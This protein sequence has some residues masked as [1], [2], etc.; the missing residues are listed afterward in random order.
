MQMVRPVNGYTSRV[1]RFQGAPQGEA[2]SPPAGACRQVVPRL[3]GRMGRVVIVD[4]IKT[5]TGDDADVGM[6]S[7]PGR[8]ARRFSRRSTPP[9]SVRCERSGKQ[10]VDRAV[11]RV[12]EPVLPFYIQGPTEMG[13]QALAIWR[14]CSIS[15]RSLATPDSSPGSIGP[16]DS[17]LT[18]SIGTLGDHPGLVVDPFHR[19]TGLAGIK[20]VESSSSNGRMSRKTNRDPDPVGRTHGEVPSTSPRP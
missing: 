1:V 3:C 7:T 9:P 18:Q 8:S 19:G 2:T 17:S 4:Q 5:H 15:S 11:P 13:L 16:T 20:V 6:P 12:I 10:D 14:M